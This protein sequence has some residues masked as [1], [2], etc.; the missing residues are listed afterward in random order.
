MNTT[1]CLNEDEMIEAVILLLNTKGYVVKTHLGVGGQGKNE[2][3]ISFRHEEVE[4]VN[5][6][7]IYKTVVEVENKDAEFSTPPEAELT[8]R[9]IV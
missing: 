1:I 4:R 2:P 9:D 8:E 5:G 3:S 6:L 7:F